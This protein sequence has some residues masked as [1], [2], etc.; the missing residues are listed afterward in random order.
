[1][2]QIQNGLTPTYTRSLL[3]NYYRGLKHLINIHMPDKAE[4]ILAY[5]VKPGDA[6][7][8]AGIVCE[9]NPKTILEIGSYC[10]ISTGLLALLAPS[11]IIECIDPWLPT[12][13]FNPYT[14]FESL[15]DESLVRVRTFRGHLGCDCETVYTHVTNNSETMPTVLPTRQR[16]D[17]VF[18]DG[19]HRTS[20]SIMY[21]MLTCNRTDCIVYHDSNLPQHRQAFDI[22]NHDYPGV[23]EM[24]HYPE[25]E[26]G[27]S[28]FYRSSSGANS[29]A[30]TR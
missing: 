30:T 20:S 13:D 26:N 3:R 5:S 4:E 19:D 21:F 29:N 6:K 16:Y 18:I 27:I 10:G 12:G 2:H 14:L 7:V 22:I 8:L 28:V 9:I 15:L 17:L 11:A 23:W 25:T 24:R 1:M